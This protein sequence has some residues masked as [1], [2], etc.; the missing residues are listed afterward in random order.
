MSTAHAGPRTRSRIPLAALLVVLA[1][2]GAC[3]G[4]A[5]GAVEMSVDE[6]AAAR[7]RLEAS[8]GGRLVLRAIEAAGGLELW[9][10]TP[11]SAY[12]WEYSNTGSDVRFKSFL[13]AHNRTREVYHHLVSLGTPRE[14]L[15]VDGSFAWD[16]EEAWIHPAEI[17]A[18]NPRFWATTGY[19][20]SSIPFVLADPGI[21]YEVLP[22]AELD[23]EMYDMVR[24]G[25]EPGIGDAS[26]TYVLYVDKETSRVEAIRYT[27]TYGGRP[28]RGETL[29]YYRDYVT[30]DGFTVPTHLVGHTF[31]DGAPGEA[32]NEAWVTDISFTQPFDS[33]R[34][35]M[36]ADGRIQPFTPT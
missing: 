18:I 24:V 32:R 19:Y 28:A 5:P 8:E 29:M 7:A 16:G 33:T 22:D 27:V 6:A 20:F 26:D 12:G 14:P 31:L 21:V 30:V 11:T 17:D 35:E 34:L 9:Y 36:P 4:D 3:Q 10:A 15:P 13:V 2:T 1:M 23:G 25:Y